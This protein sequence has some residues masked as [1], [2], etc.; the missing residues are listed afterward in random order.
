MQFHPKTSLTLSSFPEVKLNVSPLTHC[1]YVPKAN[2][3]TVGI[4]IV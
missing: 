1:E 3:L 2:E 4:I